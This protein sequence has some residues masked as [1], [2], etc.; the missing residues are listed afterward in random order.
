MPPDFSTGDRDERLVDEQLHLSAPEMVYRAEP[1]RAAQLVAKPCPTLLTVIVTSK[2]LSSKDVKITFKNNTTVGHVLTG[3]SLTRPQGTNGNLNNTKP[4]REHDLI[5]RRPATA[6][7]ARR[8][9]GPA[10]APCRALSLRSGQRKPG[11]SQTTS[12]CDPA[13]CQLIAAKRSN[14]NYAR[15]DSG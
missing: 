11:G 14:L 1:N 12:V 2:S 15:T 4:G 13:A 5:T 9:S 10:L 6:R 8:P 7:L 3:L